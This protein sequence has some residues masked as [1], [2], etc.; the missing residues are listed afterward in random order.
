[1]SIFIRLHCVDTANTRVWVC[2]CLCLC[3]PAR[4]CSHVRACLHV[5]AL[6]NLGFA[7]NRAIY[8]CIFIPTC[9]DYT[10]ACVRACARWKHFSFYVDA[11]TWQRSTSG[12]PIAHAYRKFSRLISRDRGSRWAEVYTPIWLIVVRLRTAA[13]PDTGVFTIV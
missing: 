5:L 11:N 6:C 7:C 3:A 10:R 2:V 8:V 4:A 12:W 9:H 1:M 13:K